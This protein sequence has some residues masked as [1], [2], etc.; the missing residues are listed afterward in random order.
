MAIAVRATAQADPSETR[1]V[2]GLV[3]RAEAKG[4]RPIANVRVVLHR[5]GADRAGPLDSALTGRTA[6][7]PST[8]AFSYQGLAVSGRRSSSFGAMR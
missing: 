4:P 1:R 2:D 8:P 5:V 3:M 6:T 7:R